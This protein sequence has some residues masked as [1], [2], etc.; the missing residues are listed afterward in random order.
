MGENE[1]KDFKDT[2]FSENGNYTQFTLEDGEL[3]EYYFNVLMG[4]SIEDRREF[5]F[6]ETN[7]SE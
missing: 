6:K 3:A 1:A 2:I 4:S 7:W 5:I